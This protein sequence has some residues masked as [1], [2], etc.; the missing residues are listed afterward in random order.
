MSTIVLSRSLSNSVFVMWHLFMSFIC[1][2]SYKVMILLIVELFSFQIF[3][4]KTKNYLILCGELIYMISKKII[5][6]QKEFGW[7]KYELQPYFFD[8]LVLCKMCHG[9]SQGDS[10]SCQAVSELI[11]VLDG[12]LTVK[13]EKVKGEW[14]EE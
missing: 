2:F 8:P 14:S 12:N 1:L 6:L 13:E 7:P 9:D 5:W 4:H 10:R 3:I 11:E